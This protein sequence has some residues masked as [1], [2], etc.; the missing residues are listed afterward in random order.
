[1]AVR[2]RI[3]V[4]GTSQLG[5]TVATSEIADLAVTTGKL[6]ADAVDGDKL[7]D[8]ALDSEHYTDGSI[9]SEHVAAATLA[10][11]RLAS[12]LVKEPGHVAVGRLD[13]A[14]V[15]NA[16]VTVTIGA[17][18]YLE[19]DAPTSTNGEWTNGGS[20]NDSA[21][22]L[23]AAINDD[24]RGGNDY[25]AVV[26]TDT[27]FVFA[28]VVGTAGNVAASVSAGEPASIEALVGGTAAVV[29]QQAHIM[30]T[31]TALEVAVASNAPEVLIP[32]PFDAVYFSFQVYDS[33]GGIYATELT[34]RGTV[35]AASAPVKA[36]FKLAN[37]GAADVQAGDIIRLVVQ[38]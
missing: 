22:S 6:A 16:A 18:T 24:T 12:F 26:S 20:A 11:D 14:A 25:C 21:V 29:K 33:T 36:Y 31:V 23:A 38:D 28:R 30:H 19:N 32:L 35:V 34:A 13:F 1:M 8:N 7:A 5:T 4:K 27:V 10:D 15:A 3:S 17:Q 37:N 2:E 9:D